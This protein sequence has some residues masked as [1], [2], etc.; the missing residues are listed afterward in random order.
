[1]CLELVFKTGTGALQRYT[2]Y[3]YVL[4]LA[5]DNNNA[6]FEAPTWLWLKQLAKLHKHNTAHMMYIKKKIAIS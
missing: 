6:N 3:Y 4:N 1:M 5:N 2:K